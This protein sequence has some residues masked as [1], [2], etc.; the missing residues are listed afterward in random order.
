MS[1]YFLTEDKMG[2]TDITVF[3]RA[4]I[5]SADGRYPLATSIIVSR[6]AVKRQCASFCFAIGTANCTS[7]FHHL[8]VLL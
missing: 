7:L 5:L 4:P 6:E 3:S 2:G 1:H 8:L